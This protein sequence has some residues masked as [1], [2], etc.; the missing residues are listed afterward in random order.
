[1]GVLLQKTANNETILSSIWFTTLTFLGCSYVSGLVC[2]HGS[3]LCFV[4]TSASGLN[5]AATAV[6]CLF[7]FNLSYSLGYRY[8]KPWERSNLSLC[9]ALPGR[10]S[11]LLARP[12]LWLVASRIAGLA[13]EIWAGTVKAN[14]LR[15]SSLDRSEA[16]WHRCLWIQHQRHRRTSWVAS[17]SSSAARASGPS[18]VKC[19]CLLACL[20]W[21]SHWWWDLRQAFR[22]SPGSRS[23]WSGYCLS[24]SRISWTVRHG[25]TYNHNRLSV[26][27]RFLRRRAP[28]SCLR[29]SWFHWMW[30]GFAQV[31]RSLAHI[32]VWGPTSIWIDCRPSWY[33]LASFC[34]ESSFIC[35]MTS[36]FLTPWPA[37]KSSHNRNQLSFLALR[38]FP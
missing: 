30:L 35:A 38:F 13:F 24:V 28:W 22:S 7:C 29:F 12:S 36:N 6:S 23:F 11:L 2:R 33:L 20:K 8:L 3:W 5:T 16:L 14:W 25:R 37:L 17:Y 19:Q 34:S 27:G 4:F 31:Q 10:T 18:S 15:F 26:F 1:M 9:A 21:S 32:W